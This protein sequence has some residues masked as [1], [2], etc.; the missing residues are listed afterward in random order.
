MSLILLSTG[1]VPTHTTLKSSLLF[2][3]CHLHAMKWNISLLLFASS[4]IQRTAVA[5]IMTFRITTS[6]L[7]TVMTRPPV[8]MSFTFPKTTALMTANILPTAAMPARDM[9]NVSTRITVWVR[10]AVVYMKNANATPVPDMSLKAIFPAATTKSGKP[11]IPA[12]GRN[13]ST[14]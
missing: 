9:S 1:M 2:H 6:V 5:E 3:T 13:I 10:L 8:P 12:T 4:P 14:R 7:R 11:A